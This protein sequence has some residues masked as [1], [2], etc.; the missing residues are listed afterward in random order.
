MNVPTTRQ[1]RDRMGLS[2]R[3]MAELLGVSKKA[4]ESY[5]Q[6]WRNVPP[7]VEQMVLLHTILLRGRDLR[8]VKACWQQKDYDRAVCAQCPARHIHAPGF[9]W[10][11]TGTLCGG[12]STGS[13]KAKRK[14]CLKCIVLKRLLVQNGAG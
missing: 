5:E 8:K 10:L 7:H 13:W 4:I 3:E 1:L 9:C 6:G 2:Q 14:L 12:K 11:V